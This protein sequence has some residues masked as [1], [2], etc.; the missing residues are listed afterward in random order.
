MNN[1]NL[2]PNERRTP[3]ELREITQKGGKASG[4]ARRR[5][6]SM[7]NVFQQIKKLPVQDGELKKQLEAV[8]IDD[9]DI[10]YG[11]AMAWSTIYNAMK[12]NSQ[13]MRLAFEMM[14]DDP[15]IALKKQEVQLK[16]KALEY[17]MAREAVE[18]NETI[19]FTYSREEADG[20]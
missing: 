15:T 16:K 14:G 19:T 5:N 4:R 7:Q 9:E 3:S 13:M 10:T 6:K 1:E 11:A 2:I 8:G 18:S 17:D 12:G 20:D